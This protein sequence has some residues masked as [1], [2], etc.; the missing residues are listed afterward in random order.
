MKK[1]LLIISLTIF[2]ITVVKSQEKIQF[3]VKGS[4]N[5]TNMTSDIMFDQE[6]KIGFQIG[7]LA[8][9]PF[10]T[11]F[12]LQPEILY[13]KQGVKG[14]ISFDAII[15]FTKPRHFKIYY[16]IVTK[17]FLYLINTRIISVHQGKAHPGNQSTY[18]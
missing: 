15:F 4:I 14:K 17:L 12:S 6:Y 2:T 11:K 7:V 9:I 3:G 10:G 18:K 13:S 16:I 5:F 1:T 8:E